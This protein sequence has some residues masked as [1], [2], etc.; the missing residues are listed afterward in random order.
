MRISSNKDIRNF[1]K[2]LLDKGIGRLENGKKHAY[3]IIHTTRL[4]IPCTPSC[5]R[6]FVK[7]KCDVKR[8]I[9]TI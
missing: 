6:S 5:N 4:T 9:A 8:I 7:F 3:L 1:V 2:K